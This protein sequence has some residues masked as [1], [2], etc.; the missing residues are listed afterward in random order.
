MTRVLDLFGGMGGW[1]EGL[2]ALGL[3]EVGVE[4]D[5]DACATRRA[6]GHPVIRA[7]VTDFP[8]DH[9]AGRVD[10]LIA[11]PPCPA[12][13]SA[14]K[15]EGRALT[16]HYVSCIGRGDWREGL[17]VPGGEVL[18]VGRWAETVRP[19]WVAC[20]Q[21]PSV[22]PIWRAYRD[23]WRAL[24][25]WSVWC[26]KLDPADYGVPQNRPRA[27]LLARTDG[28]PA[29]PPEPTH[30]RFGGVS[31]FGEVVE[32]WVSM[33]EALGWGLPAQPSPVVVTAR[34]RQ[35]GHDV[36]RGSSWRADWFQRQQEAGNWVLRTG[37]NS[38]VTG[39]TADD[40]QLYER[41]VARP[42]PTLDTKAGTAW[43]FDRP[44][45][46]VAGDPRI[47]AR[48][49]HDHGT[50]G[51]NAKTTD[52]VQAGDYEGTEPIKLTLAEALIL[53]GFRPDYPLSG[54]KTARF[55]QV[56]NAVPPPF[57]AAIVGSLL[58]LDWRNREAA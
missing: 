23:R 26:G 39:R 40:V 27:I 34:N 31:L 1:A 20:E 46:T 16:D 45:T 12:F 49:H 38:M 35:T 53:Q 41:S 9:L 48:C 13:S 43:V 30:G 7:D 21:V 8:L 22:L 24:H 44:A 37:N 51:A 5:P 28:H 4:W 15:G 19:R 58:G 14:G 54:T 33:A 29:L 55:S 52:Q 56:G 10:G 2:R 57:A 6:A 25:G 11:S 47:T 18:E 17:G 32:P 50:Q 42:A 36:L 3:S